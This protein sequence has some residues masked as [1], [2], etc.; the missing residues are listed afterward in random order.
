MPTARKLAFAAVT[1][2]RMGRGS[3]FHLLPED[4]MRL[5]LDNH[6]NY[7]GG[8]VGVL[9]AWDTY[10]AHQRWIQLGFA[11]GLLRHS[12]LNIFSEVCNGLG[13]NK[14][15]QCHVCFILLKSYLDSCISHYYP[16]RT[17]T[18][19]NS[20]VKIT[21]VFY[22]LRDKTEGILSLDEAVRDVEALHQ[23]F[24]KIFQM[25]EI[26]YMFRRGLNGYL[27]NFQARCRE[28]ISQCVK[29][30]KRAQTLINRWEFVCTGDSQVRIYRP[31]YMHKRQDILTKICQ[32]IA[33]CVQRML[34]GGKHTRRVHAHLE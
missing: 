14:G 26:S 18:V 16:I 23:V 4:V 11:M 17:D 12:F 21:S 13:H 19:P 3:V 32:T 28:A 20:D 8:V 1:H 22:H 34:R 27:F 6:I 9:E 33:S 24:D 7:G 31:L 15:G 2:S 29:Q 10:D 30:A 5:V 25:P